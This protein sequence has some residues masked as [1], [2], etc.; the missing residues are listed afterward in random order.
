MTQSHKHS[1]IETV[2]NIG[3]GFIIGVLLNYTV[4]PFFVEDTITGPMSFSIGAI[5][6]TVSV[7][8]SYAFRRIFTHLT[9]GE[10]CGKV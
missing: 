2:A 4:L 6:S 8:R 5:Y 3:S 7:I 1:L 9:E 10:K